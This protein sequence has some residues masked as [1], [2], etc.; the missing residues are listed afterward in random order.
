MQKNKYKSH[1][2]KSGNVWLN[3]WDE[4]GAYKRGSIEVEGET[5]SGYRIIRRGSLLGKELTS[6]SNI[7]LG[8][9]GVYFEKRKDA[10]NFA[11]VLAMHFSGD[12]P[13]RDFIDPTI[14][15]GYQSRR[16]TFS[17]ARTEL[18][19]QGV[20]PRRPNGGLGRT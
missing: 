14:F 12:L 2:E 6:L 5:A 19:W 8:D 15:N 11:L 7:I 4:E 16:I 17:K 1:E 10:E 9:A 18:F 13:S 20:S 3:V